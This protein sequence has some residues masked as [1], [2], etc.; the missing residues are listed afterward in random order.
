MIYD[1]VYLIVI[2][3]NHTSENAVSW[4][5][6]PKKSSWLITLPVYKR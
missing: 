1:T 3:I 4:S 5:M 2:R 6:V